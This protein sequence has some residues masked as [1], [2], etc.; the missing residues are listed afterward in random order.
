MTTLYVNPTSTKWSTMTLG[1][2][3]GGPYTLGPG[4][5][6]AETIVDLNGASDPSLNGG[7]FDIDQTGGVTCAAIIDSTRTGLDIASI[8][9]HASKNIHGNVGNNTADGGLTGAKIM[10]WGGDASGAF[11]LY[12]NF[13]SGLFEMSA[14]TFVGG[15]MSVTFHGSIHGSIY[16]NTNDTVKWT[17]TIVQPANCYAAIISGVWLLLRLIRRQASPSGTVGGRIAGT[18]TPRLR[19]AAE[20]D[21]AASLRPT[22]S[23]II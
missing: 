16:W 20:S 5:V 3:A 13:L 22:T 17:G 19:S 8:T 14:L 7:S 21:T 6:A 18:N 1:T 9:V 15:S 11:A 2:A 12:G 4:D 10:M 23:G